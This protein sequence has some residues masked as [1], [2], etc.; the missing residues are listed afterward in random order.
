MQ[1]P[2]WIKPAIW[3]A[4]AG[5]AI[6]AITGFSQLGWTTSATAEKIAQE[7]A[8]AAVVSALVPFC[9]AKAEL[10][11]DKTVLT[12][13]QADSAWYT[14]SDIVAKAGWA[15]VGN[16]KLPDSALAQACADK[17]ARAKAG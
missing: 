1:V 6:M 11:P 16:D 3:G 12:K 7:R 4:V 14:R 15:T 8:G 10:D 5:A 13:L 17:L 2:V 9:I